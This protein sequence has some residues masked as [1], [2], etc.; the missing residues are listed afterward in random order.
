M[1]QSINDHVSTLG[2]YNI[3]NTVGTGCFVRLQLLKLRADLL[4]GD[5]ASAAAL[6][7]VFRVCQCVINWGLRVGDSGRGR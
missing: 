4:R 2:E 6:F 5:F 3:G 1:R 7:G